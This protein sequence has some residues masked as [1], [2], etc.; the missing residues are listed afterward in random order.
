MFL[1][2]IPVLG[3]HQ[4]T[5]SSPGPD[6]GG[7]AISAS[8]FERQMRFLHD[9]GYTCRSLGE[10][11]RFSGNEHR[12]E[13]KT[14][15]LTFDDGYEDFFTQAYP[16]LRRHGFTATVFLVADRVGDQSNWEQ[17]TATPTL[18]WG[19]IKTLL[20][21]G[22][23]FGSHTCTHRRL[24]RLSIEDI[25]HELS[26]SKTRL[27]SELHQE[28]QLLAYPYGDSNSAIQSIAMQSGYAAAC[29][30]SRGKSGRFNIWRRLVC[31]NDSMTSFAYKL[32]Q[33]YA[34][35]GWFREETAAGHLLRQIKRRLYP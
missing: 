30:V 22:F 1:A 13:P 11:L 27:T 21:D 28:V 25:R 33:W 18:T 19:Q 5:P 8:Q 31:A 3:Y 16:I 12:S 26:E 17:E 9:H 20:E 32:T 29:G 24:T 6:G 7:F 34:Y 23:S 4:I 14:F 15:A 2:D 35:P 10:L